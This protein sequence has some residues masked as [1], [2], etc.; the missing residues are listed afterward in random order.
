M[1]V[2]DVVFLNSNLEILIT[3]ELVLND[4]PKGA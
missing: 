3:V 4:E 2:G 1:S